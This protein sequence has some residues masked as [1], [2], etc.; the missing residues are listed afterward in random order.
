M[1]TLYQVDDGFACYGLIVE[2]NIIV[3]VAPIGYKRYYNKSIKQT[4]IT[5]LNKGSKV[6]GLINAQ[7][8]EITKK[9]DQ[10]AG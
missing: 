9:G 4:I 2:N 3:E 1:Q 10:N 5:E 6:F 7:W 8:A